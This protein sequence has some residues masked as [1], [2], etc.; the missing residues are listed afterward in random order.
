MMKGIP[1]PKTCN[2]TSV[3]SVFSVPSVTCKTITFCCLLVMSLSSPL[4]K[5]FPY[6]D[7]ECFIV[8]FKSSAHLSGSVSEGALEKWDFLEPQVT[9]SV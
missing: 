2:K 1:K 3:L 5:M 9:G 7:V 4:N 8:G 6:T